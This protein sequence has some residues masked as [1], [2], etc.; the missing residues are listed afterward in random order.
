MLLKAHQRIQWTNAFLPTRHRASIN[1]LVVCFFISWYEK[2]QPSSRRG[3]LRIRNSANKNPKWDWTWKVLVPVFQ[4]AS[5][6]SSFT[7]QFLIY[8]SCVVFMM[9]ITLK[10]FAIMLLLISYRVTQEKRVLLGR[11]DTWWALFFAVGSVQKDL[12]E[13]CCIN[14]DEFN[15]V[16]VCVCVHVFLFSPQVL[17]KCVFPGSSW[18][19]RT[20]WLS[21]APRCKGELFI[22]DKEYMYQ[23]FDWLEEAELFIFKWEWF[24]KNLFPRGSL[25]IGSVRGEGS[26]G[27]I[28]S[29]ASLYI[30]H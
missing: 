8:W 28:S 6:T 3:C 11:K 14:A 27:N 22:S 10:C 5:P 15:P 18:P 29:D 7:A 26:D 21:G 9:V 12:H 4:S 20:H 24:A 17:T 16:C 19:S 2:S 25:Q 1:V 13:M 30:K 23:C